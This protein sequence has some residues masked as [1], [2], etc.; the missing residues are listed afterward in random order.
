MAAAPIWIIFEYFRGHAG[1]LSYP[2]PYLSLT[3]YLQVPLI[4]IST[5]TG[6]YGI[7]FLIILMNGAIVDFLLYLVHFRREDQNVIPQGTNYRLSSICPWKILTNPALR[8]VGVL[9]LL[10]M[11]WISGW[12]LIPPRQEGPPLSIT[13]VQGN[14]PQNIKWDKNY[15]DWIWSNSL[16]SN[17]ASRPVKPPTDCLAG[18]LHPGPCFDQPR[19]LYP[20]GLFDPPNQRL[21]PVGKR[22]IP[23]I[24]AFP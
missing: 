13:V 9:L 15:K 8:M 5:I 24:N 23:Q 3:Q 10:G 4:Q 11:I 17:P 14:I 2:W 16:V 20:T 6:A 22:R 19:F 1:F 21:P 18:S 7:S 12:F